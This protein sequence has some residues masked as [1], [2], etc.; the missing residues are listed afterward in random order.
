MLDFPS[1]S[2]MTAAEYEPPR[3]P[4]NIE[5]EQCLLGTLLVIPAAYGRVESFLHAEHFG[6]AVHARIYAAIGALIAEGVQPDAVLVKDRLG[7]EPVLVPMGGLGGY[8]AKLLGAAMPPANAE[9]YGK[10]IIEAANRRS[11]MQ[12][13]IDATR[14]ANNP[15]VA[16]EQLAARIDAEL[17]RLAD[18]TTSQF[19]ITRASDLA[20]KP[21]PVRV[22]IVPE[23]IPARQVTL[24]T[25]DGGVGK[26]LIA[27]Q[28]QIAAASA[29]QWFGLPVIPCRSL[30]MYAEDDEDELHYRLAAL[31]ELM[32]VDIAS[33]DKMAWRC[34]VG[35][36]A[37]L[38]EPDE[39][40]TVQPTDYFRKIEREAVNFGARLLV[41]DAATNFY[42]ADEIQR[43]QVNSFLRL[44]RQLA[45]RIDGAVILLAHPS[46]AGMANGTG[47]S[48][49]THWNNAVRSRLY[50]TSASE[51][52]ADTGE[53]TLTK[54]KANY[55]S[56]G[57]IIR[58]HWHRGGFVPVDQP[59]SIDRTAQRSK[60]DRVFRALLVATYGEGT[61]TSP[62]PISKNYAPNV[63]AKRPDREG[64]GKPA[65]EDALLRLMHAGTVKTELYGRAAN[66]HTRLALS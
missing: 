42:G 16:P 58:V 62:N 47:L 54:L 37:E 11:L 9:H 35:D 27:M 44:L 63:F 30:G 66:Q 40:G 43:R 10:A 36:N 4:V 1:V 29:Q 57:D 28:L 31:A 12:V 59:G 8:I 56:K 17:R 25:G 13:G 7:E 65:F 19:K 26:S 45:L 52:G 49:S 48:G 33:L 34:A 64:L 14:E 51:D 50:F 2:A 3:L 53:R 61:W 15:A 23:W 60:S 5:A 24:L 20:G 46:L 39:R 21:V 6:N 22:S 41:I 55:S 38:I 18:V 32:Q